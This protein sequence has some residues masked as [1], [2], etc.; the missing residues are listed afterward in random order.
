[1]PRRALRQAPRRPIVLCGHMKNDNQSLVLASLTGFGF[2]GVLGGFAVGS[3]VDIL[4]LPIPSLQG[5]FLGGVVGALT[6]LIAARIVTPRL[7]G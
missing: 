5:Y 2:G 4:G 6:G 1:M 7:L 3:A